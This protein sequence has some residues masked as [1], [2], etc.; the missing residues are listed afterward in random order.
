[1]HLQSTLPPPS[2]DLYDST[3]NC[4][5]IL[6]ATDDEGPSWHDLLD[7]KKQRPRN[8]RRKLKQKEK[9]FDRESNHSG[10]HRSTS[11]IR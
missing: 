5:L 4:C 11:S 7:N 1:M 8:R 10:V 6:A 2:T 3:V 9:D